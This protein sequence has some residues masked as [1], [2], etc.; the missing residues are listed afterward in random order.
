MDIDSREVAKKYDSIKEIW[1]KDDKWHRHTFNF[2][3]KFIWRSYNKIL[4]SKEMQ[5]LNAGAGGHCYNLPVG[6]FVHIDIA[7]NKIRNL[8]NSIL[9]NIE[10][11]PI[12]EEEFELIICVGSVINYCDPIKVIG[13]FNRIL[14]KG[15]YIILEFESSQTLELIGTINYSK[16]VV[17]TDTFYFG[18]KERLWYYSEKFITE[19]LS[20]N[21]MQ[22]LN[23]DKC[24]IISPLIYR[25]FKNENFAAFFTTFDFLFK[26]LP[27]INKP[28]SNIIY[29]IRKY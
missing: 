7:T 3:K 24:H 1:H 5:I 15:G 21:K 16:K 11:I 13:E 6:R 27:F 25:I 20:L 9:A 22:I 19:L 23:V 10:H 18:K 8:S 28:S 17:L 29:F 26:Y 4:S 12:S 2:I 14:K